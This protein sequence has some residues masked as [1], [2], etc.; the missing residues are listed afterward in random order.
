MYKMAG[1]A[2]ALL[3]G[4]GLALCGS[5]LAQVGITAVPGDTAPITV[6]YPTAAPAATQRFGPFEDARF[7]PLVNT[8]RVGVYGMSAG[9]LTALLLAGADWN[10]ANL[11]RHCA[12]H[13]D[14]DAGLCLFGRPSA[15][16]DAQRTRAYWGPPPPG[17]LPR[18][19]RT[20]RYL[21]MAPGLVES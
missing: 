5:A 8:D 6:A 18:D 15:D 9:G 13:L 12:A 16:A 3:A 2:R 11:L 21:R 4:T 20:I 7:G 14:D 17:D 19:L 1:L 10:L